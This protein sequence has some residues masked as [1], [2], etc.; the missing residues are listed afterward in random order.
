M[1][2]RAGRQADVAA[3]VGFHDQAHFTRH[4]KRHTATTPASYARSH[5]RRAR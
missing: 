2:S 1:L 4:F 3:A 5:T